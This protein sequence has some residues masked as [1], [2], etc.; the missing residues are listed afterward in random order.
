MRWSRMLQTI[1]VHCEGEIG[2]VVTG[3]LLNG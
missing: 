1:D 2:R 3:N